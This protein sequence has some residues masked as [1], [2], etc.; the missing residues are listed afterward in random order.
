MDRLYESLDASTN[1]VVK[2]LTAIWL[3]ILKTKCDEWRGCIDLTE[4][5]GKCIV[6]NIDAYFSNQV[7]HNGSL[8]MNTY[9]SQRLLQ[10]VY[11]QQK[12][13]TT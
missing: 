3:K 13:T 9:L 12:I 10:A 6:Q 8:R 4:T 5:E 2:D 1:G 11:W 7:L